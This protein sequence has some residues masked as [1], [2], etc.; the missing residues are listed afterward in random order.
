M[1]VMKKNL[2]KDRRFSPLFWTQ[3]LGAFNDNAFKNAIVILIAFKGLSIGHVAPKQMVALCGAIFILPFFLFSGTAGRLADK[4]SKSRIVVWV[5]GCEVLIMT[6][7]AFGFVGGH[8][9]LLLGALFLMGVHSTIFGP[10]KYSILP[11]LLDPEEL[12]SGTAYVEMGTFIAILLGTILGGL[13]IAIPGIGPWAVGAAVIALAATGCATGLRIGKLPP[14]AP[15]LAVGFNPITPTIEIL[16]LAAGEKSV[17]WSILGISWFWFLGASVLSLLPTY[18]KEFLHADESVATFFLALFS[19]GVGSG[20]ML[21]KRLSSRKLELGLV[22]V[23]SLGLSLFALDLFLAGQPAPLASIAPGGLSV[24]GLLSS[25]QGWRIALDFILFSVFG[26]VFIVPLYTLI[27]QRGEAGERSRVI[28]GNNILNA[29][30]MVASAVFLVVLFAKNYTI[31]QIFLILSLLN[32]VFPICVSPAVPEFPSAFV[33]WAW[34]HLFHATE[35]TG[36]ENIPSEGP[37]ILVCDFAPGTTW[38]MAA[39]L[40]RRPVRFVIADGARPGF[41]ERLVRRGAGARALCS[42]DPSSLSESDIETIARA[43]RAGEIVGIARKGLLKEKMDRMLGIIE[44]SDNETGSE[45]T[46]VIS[47]SA[48]RRPTGTAGGSAVTWFSL[49]RGRLRPRISLTMAI[50]RREEH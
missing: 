17:F 49:L 24:L 12:V 4:Y 9:S 39:A 41:F 11:Q 2:L 37:A 50:V 35:A 38:I 36:E 7:G 45:R 21:F 25:F 8:I 15:G 44:F 46:P 1:G 6:V 18:C 26:G 42:T 33:A 27:Q 48:V 29:F 23:G 13:L 31:P 5:K 3:F 32:L 19:I 40:C 34:A 47:V 14:T 16:R 43:L 10:V 20:S 22:Q 30:F 28:A